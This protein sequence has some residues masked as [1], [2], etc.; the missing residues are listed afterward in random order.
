MENRFAG[1]AD[2]GGRR[3][4]RLSQED[5]QAFPDA[6]GSSRTKSVKLNDLSQI[7]SRIDVK[8][9]RR[10]I[11][12]RLWK[13]VAVLVAL[14][15]GMAVFAWSV[16][17][18]NTAPAALTMDVERIAAVLS[19]TFLLFAA[20]LSLLIGW[21]RAGSDIDYKGRYRWWKWLAVGQAVVAVLLLSD[22]TSSL[23][24]I[25]SA[26]LEPLMGTITAARYAIVIVPSMAFAGIVLS[27]IL[28]DMNRSFWSQSLLAAAV[29]TII[30]RFMLIHGAA[31]TT[32]N[33]NILSTMTLGASF[34]TFASMLLHCRFVAFIC[35]DPPVAGRNAV[36]ST[37]DV[38]D[39]PRPSKRVLEQLEPE[40]NDSKPTPTVSTTAAEKS[41]A[42][43][44]P[45]A[46]NKKRR[47]KAA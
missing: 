38:A 34:A 13:H 12:P 6:A 20:Q 17:S 15:V 4:R 25:V 22:A 32:I 21:I 5:E 37:R 8:L 9:L 7:A 1:A 23:P 14:L 30:V 36:L 46:K 24:T 33:A 10:A 44:K 3:R 31:T 40:A 18:N 28:P 29:L 45:T 11:S 27:R 39:I 41:P 26:L 42:T 2:L 19:G 43:Q 35:N 16:N 47:R